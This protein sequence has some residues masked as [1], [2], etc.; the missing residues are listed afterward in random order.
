MGRHETTSDGESTAN[1]ACRALGFFGSIQQLTC[2]ARCGCVLPGGKNTK[3]KVFNLM[4][5]NMH[6]LCDECFD[7][8][9]E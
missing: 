5:P 6:F 4:K 7:Q 9:P 2:C 8:L 3:R 1:W